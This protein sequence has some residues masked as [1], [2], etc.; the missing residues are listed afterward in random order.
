MAYKTA[1]CGLNRVF[2]SEEFVVKTFN[3]KHMTLIK[4]D[5]DTEVKLEIKNTNVFKPIYGITVHK[6][7]GMTITKPYSIYEYEKMKHDMLYVSL[8][9]T[10]AKEHVN[11]C[12]VNVLRP[13]TG[14]I[15]R[16][17]LNGKSYIG[18]TRKTIKE[19]QEEHKNCNKTFKFG[20]AIKEHGYDNFH[21]EVLETIKFGEASDLHDLENTYITK[22]DSVKNGLNTRRNLKHENE[23]E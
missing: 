11:F 1:G 12:K 3:D 13:Y 2:N 5:D 21:F 9:R 15:Y 23:C 18:S 6:A 4:M 19:R 7:Q 8:T 14:Y 17:S 16:Y 10:S 22:Y 20:R